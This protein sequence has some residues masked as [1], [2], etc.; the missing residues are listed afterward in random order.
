M[1]LAK[2]HIQARLDLAARQQGAGRKI[3]WG[4]WGFVQILSEA[5]DHMAKF[6][7]KDFVLK[8]T[9]A[10][11]LLAFRPDV[12]G[13]LVVVR[14]DLILQATAISLR[15]THGLRP[16]LCQERLAQAALWGE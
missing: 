10:N 13:N 14:D 3:N 6:Q 8:A 4:P 11:Q 2:K 9:V 16:A 15:P 7:E 12:A 5:C 1:R